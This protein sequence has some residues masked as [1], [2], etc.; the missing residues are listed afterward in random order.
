M[1]ERTGRIVVGLAAG[2]ALAA[3]APACAQQQAEAS[4][5]ALVGFHDLQGRSA[6]QPLV[7]R[8]GNR[9]IAYIGHHGDNLPN[10]LTGRQ[11]D[12][13]TSILDVTDPKQPKM[14]AHIPGEPGKTERGGAQMVRV[15]NGSD[16]PRADKG[17]VY[18]L[19][20]FGNAAQ[21]IWDV[22]DPSS[23]SHLTTII[24]GHKDTHKNAWECNT[25]I[26]YL[27]ADGRPEGFRSSRITKIYD[28]SDPAN[29]KFIRNFALVGQEP[30]STMKQVPEGLHGAIIAGNRVYFG[31]GTLLGGVIQIVDRDKLLKGNPESKDPFAPTPE[32]LLYPQ[33]GRSDMYPTIGAHTTLPILGM[34]VEAFSSFV[35]QSPGS[36]TGRP[37]T[38]DLVLAVNES[39]QNE[40]REDYHMA[41]MV[42]I[43]DEARPF[44]I[45]SFH[46]PEKAGKF[47]DRGG[48]FGA[49]ASHENMTPIYHKRLAFVTWFN[50][51]L[52]VIDYRNPFALQEVAYY[53]PAITKNTAERCLNV[54]GVERCKIAIQSNNPE[55]DDRGYIYVVDRANTGMHILELTGSARAIFRYSTAPGNPIAENEGNRVFEVSVGLTI[56]HQPSTSERWSLRATDCARSAVKYISTLR[57]KITSIALV[58]FS[59]DG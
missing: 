48:R 58:L 43:T 49:H 29:P 8:Q 23:P 39:T 18:L 46:V 25:G 15:C 44:T 36:R 33:V 5:M 26:A 47:C 1:F 3:A 41:F 35:P 22:T 37:T 59:S 12:N 20:P 30:G 52:R 4:N 10:P 17:K 14:L 11:E 56:N 50:G 54:N 9:W 31:Y 24:K 19:R 27:V 45:S 42:D 2:A 38:R 34:E 55:V 40:C 7:H 13:G 16:L 28:L 57:Q 21:E 6:Y 32:N 53:I 51:G